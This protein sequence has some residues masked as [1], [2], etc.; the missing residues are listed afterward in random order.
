MKANEYPLN[1]GGVFRCCIASLSEDETEAVE[2]DTRICK[3]CKSPDG[4][5]KLTNGVWAW[6]KQT[7]SPE[8]TRTE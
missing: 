2:G 3:Y 7:I 6:D 5:L 8:P 1:H 4:G